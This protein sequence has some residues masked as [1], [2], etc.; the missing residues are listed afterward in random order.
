MTWLNS[1]GLHAVVGNNKSN[2][3]VWIYSFCL[4]IFEFQHEPV[5]IAEVVEGLFG[6]GEVAG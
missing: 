5:P 6:E 3:I 4:I 2:N 1:W